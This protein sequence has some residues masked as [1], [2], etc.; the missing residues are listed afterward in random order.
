MTIKKLINELSKVENQE[1]EV[2]IITPE[3]K[4]EIEYIPS[5]TIVKFFPAMDGYRVAL[6]QGIYED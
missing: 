5:R 1:T 4:N 3:V 6:C 2:I